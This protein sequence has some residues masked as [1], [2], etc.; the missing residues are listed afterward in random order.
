MASP[1]RKSITRAHEYDAEFTRFSW[2]DRAGLGLSGA[3][4]ML[5][6]VFFV[7]SAVI[8][9]W[10]A[11]LHGAEAGNVSLLGRVSTYGRKGIL[12]GPD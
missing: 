3:G 2:L 6:G 11:D 12:A 5:L 1:G 9:G 7:L 8:A 10:V 4:V